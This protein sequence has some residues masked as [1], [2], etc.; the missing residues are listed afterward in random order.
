[1]IVSMLR[2][3]SLGVALL[4]AFTAGEIQARGIHP[5]GTPLLLIGV[6]AV[7]AGVNVAAN[8]LTRTERRELRSLRCRVR[9]LERDVEL[10]KGRYFHVREQRLLDQVELRELRLDVELCRLTAGREAG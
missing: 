4:L 7:F 6:A 5:H 10:W 1:V 3:F 8:T 2:R 9:R